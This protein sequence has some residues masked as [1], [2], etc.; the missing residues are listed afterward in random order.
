MTVFAFS[1]TYITVL[2]LSKIWRGGVCKIAASIPPT[3]EPIPRRLGYRDSAAKVTCLA[4]EG[5]VAGFTKD[6]T[7]NLDRE[8]AG[9]NS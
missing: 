9:L 5:Y 4:M 3:V 1:L 6:I 8:Y 2:R 7:A